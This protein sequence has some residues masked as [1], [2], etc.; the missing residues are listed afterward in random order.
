MNLL[1]RLITLLAVVIVWLL[2]VVLLASP[3]LGLAWAQQFLDWLA[4]AISRVQA[5]LPAW[6]FTLAR[7][8]LI[9]AATVLAISFLWAELRRQRT[10]TVRVRLQSAGDAVVT[11]DSVARR[12]AWH[13]DQL[14]DVVSATPTV[15]RK[16]SAVDIDI[17]LETAPEVEVPMKT[18][19]VVTLTRHVIEDLMGLQLRKVRVQIR[20]APFPEPL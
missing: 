8:G 4:S 11:T 20:H 3:G 13:V 16:G 19:E 12:L 6:L 2:V 15:T 7:V 17:D 18:E 10:P 9:V 5:L 1:N 14:A